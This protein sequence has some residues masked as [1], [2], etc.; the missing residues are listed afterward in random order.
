MKKLLFHRYFYYICLTEN[1]FKKWSSKTINY[2]T[3]F[4][5]TLIHALKKLENSK[6]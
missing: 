3:M 5:V 6:S 1:V 2:S 4:L